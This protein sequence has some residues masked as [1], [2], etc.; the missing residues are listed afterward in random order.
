MGV[1]LLD[2][3]TSISYSSD[4]QPRRGKFRHDIIARDQIC[5][6]TGEPYGKL[7]DAAH[8]VAHSKGDEV[9]PIACS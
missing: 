2:D 1:E 5:V 3:R 6:V 7:L 8:L 9:G 4:S